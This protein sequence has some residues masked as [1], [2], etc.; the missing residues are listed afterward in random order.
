[1]FCGDGT[2]KSITFAGVK[3]FYCNGQEGTFQWAT[4]KRHR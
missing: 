1:M 4:N 3:H 2:G